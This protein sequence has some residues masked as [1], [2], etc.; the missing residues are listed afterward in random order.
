MSQNPL[1]QFPCR[2]GLTETSW[3]DCTRKQKVI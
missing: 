1:C 2:P 3:I